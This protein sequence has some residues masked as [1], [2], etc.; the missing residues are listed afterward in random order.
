MTSRSIITETKTMSLT[1]RYP[2]T[3]RLVLIALALGSAIALIFRELPYK[4]IGNDELQLM[5]N[6]N[7]PIYDVRR[8]DEWKQTGVIEDSRLLTFTDAGGRIKPNFLSHF[9]TEINKDDAVILIC[10]TGSR[11][12]KLARYLADELGY[13]NIFNVDDGI[14]QWIREKRPISNM[15]THTS[16]MHYNTGRL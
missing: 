16:N 5:L 4:N 15:I 13:T 12:S 3:L 8:P 11:T 10:R 2:P 1:P 14:T 9:T 7:I 6:D